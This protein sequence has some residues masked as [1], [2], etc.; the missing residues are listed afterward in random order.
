MRQVQQDILSKIESSETPPQALLEIGCGSG[1]FTRSLSY[2]FPHA[3]IYGIDPDYSKLPHGSGNTD[4][5]GGSAEA[6]PF[7]SEQFDVVV[8]SMSLHHWNNKQKGIEEAFRVLAPQGH[9]IIGDPF[10]EGIMR[11]RFMAWL[12]QKTDGGKFT[13]FP[14]L[15][16]YLDN[17]GFEPMA[18]YPVRSSFGTMF[19]ITA[20]KPE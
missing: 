16:I 5:V 4:Y 7:A 13:T 8:A 19:V 9:L 11:N 10:F 17:A 12:I 3:Q 2:T 18:K 14:E 15:E 6:I 1:F 20:Q